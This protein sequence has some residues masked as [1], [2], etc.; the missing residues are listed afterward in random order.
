[1]ITFSPWMSGCKAQPGCACWLNEGAKSKSE[2]VTLQ[3]LDEI[4]AENDLCIVATGRG[5][6]QE[7]FK[8]D[9][10]RSTY[11]APPRRLAMICVHGIPMKFDYSPHFLPVKFNFFAPFGESFWVPWYSMNGQAS[12]SLV[13]EAKEGGPFDKFRGAKSGQEALDRAREVVKDMTPWD[14]EWMKGA[15]LCDDNAWLV[16][17]FVPQVRDVV[18]ELPSGRHV[19]A[20]GDTAHSLDPIGGQGANNG[21]KMTRNLIECIVEREDRTFDTDWMRMTFERFW[22]RH[23]H[24]EKFNNTL[25]EPLTN[26]GKMLLLAA[27][28]STARGRQRQPT[29]KDGECVRQQLQ[30]RAAPN[31]CVSR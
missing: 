2:S 30:R 18:G 29:A 4:S 1:M 3:R 19:M 22:N 11:V 13:F 5:E 12:W 20:L 7:L 6:I 23:H 26:P 24:T 16:G 27:F 31:R 10:A 15:E 25:L 9:E 14:Y 21:N 28:G 8:R 17:A